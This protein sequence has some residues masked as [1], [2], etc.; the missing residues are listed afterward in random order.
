MPQAWARKTEFERAIVEIIQ[1][2]KY[3]CDL[4]SLNGPFFILFT[5]S[6]FLW[7]F[8]GIYWFIFSI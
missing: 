1:K 6:S 7:Y 2:S 4:S 8:F 3:I 5:F